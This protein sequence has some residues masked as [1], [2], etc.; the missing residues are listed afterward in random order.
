MGSADDVREAS[1]RDGDERVAVLHA[2]RSCLAGPSVRVEEA[3]R[4]ASSSTRNR[5]TLTSTAPT[6]SWRSARYRQMPVRTSV[7]R[8]SWSRIIRSASAWSSG[9][10]RISPSTAQAVSAEHEA[11]AAGVGPRPR[12]SARRAAPHNPGRAYRVP[13]PVRRCPRGRPRWCSRPRSEVAC[14]GETHWP[15]SK[16]HSWA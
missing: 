2:V 8:P 13:A 7:S 6:H 4:S 12:P 9:L 10:L 3:R 1:A 11:L 5:T 15:K 16:E 14:A